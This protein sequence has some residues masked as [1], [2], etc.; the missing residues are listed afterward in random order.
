SL[1]FLL[2][3]V[4]TLRGLYHTAFTWGFVSSLGEMITQAEL[5]NMALGAYDITVELASR[6]LDDY[7][8]GDK[9]FATRYPG[10]NLDRTRC[11]I[12]L[13]KD[14]ERQL[15]E[16]QAIVNEAYDHRC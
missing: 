8:T 1:E 2:F 15:D 14:M 4:S 5:D 6:F 3:R 9:Y 12:A 11:Q 10:H 16:M 7:I 13:A